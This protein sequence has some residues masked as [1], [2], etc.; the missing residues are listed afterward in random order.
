MMQFVLPNNDEEDYA[1]C[2]NYRKYLKG[3]FHKESIG[4]VSA[5]NQFYAVL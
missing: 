5:T 1:K 3:K 4:V 2:R